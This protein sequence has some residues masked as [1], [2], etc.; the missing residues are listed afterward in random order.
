MA[1]I[2]YIAMSPMVRLAYEQLPVVWTL[3][4][5]CNGRSNP[6]DLDQKGISQNDP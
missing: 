4:S 1:S 6:C 5:H 2:F 3:S